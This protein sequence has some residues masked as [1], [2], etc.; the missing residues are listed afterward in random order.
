MVVC[1]CVYYLLIIIYYCFFNF[2]N[3]LFKSLALMVYYYYTTLE[4]FS[5]LMYTTVHGE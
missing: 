5:V 4:L 1:V 2:K 3:Y